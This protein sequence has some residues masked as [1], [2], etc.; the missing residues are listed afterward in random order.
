VGVDSKGILHPGRADIE[1]WQDEFTTK[2]RLCHESNVARRH[3]GIA[4]ALAGADVC[5]A[6]STSVPG[7]IRPEWIRAMAPRAIVFACANPLP[8]VWPWEATEAGARVVAPGRSDFPNQVNNSLGF[9]AIFRG[10]LDVR[11]RTITDEM[12]MAA[13]AE[14]A[15]VAGGRGLRDDY[16]VPTMEDE[17]LF[18]REAVAVA[19]KAQEQGVARLARSREDLAREAEA[20]IREAKTTT[21]VLME[22]GLIPRMPGE[23]S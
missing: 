8:E 5:L 6:F 4:E 14:I 17:A 16:I 13:A 11:A 18:V 3:G 7:T 21:R 22:A 2:W 19:M 23:D 9:P 10:A 1:Q 12:C 15:A 20:T